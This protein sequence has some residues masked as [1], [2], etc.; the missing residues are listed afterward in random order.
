MNKEQKIAVSRA[1]RRARAGAKIVGTAARPRLTVH[2]GVAHF[3]A[4]IIDDS[5]SMT[6]VGMS[7]FN[8]KVKGTKTDRAVALGTQIAEAAK[9]KGITTVVFDRGASQYTGRVKAFADAARAAG[10]IF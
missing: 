2:R 1:R 5:K 3:Q 7:D 4:Q 8:S 9:A 6:I 10:L